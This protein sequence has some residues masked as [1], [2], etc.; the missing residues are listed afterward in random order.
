M[1]KRRRGGRAVRKSRRRCV[2]CVKGAERGECAV[3]RRA[4]TTEGEGGGGVD[5]NAASG[6]R[7]LPTN[8]LSTKILCHAAQTNQEHWGGRTGTEGE[9]E[10]EEDAPVPLAEDRSTKRLLLFHAIQK[11][12]RISHLWKLLLQALQS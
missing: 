11:D 12:V 2:L 8:Y 6:I 7:C 9:E 4:G 5:Y 1:R 10:G 3:G